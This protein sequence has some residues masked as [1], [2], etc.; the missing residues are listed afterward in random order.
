VSFLPAI[1]VALCLALPTSVH[2]RN[3]DLVP[4]TFVRFPSGAVPDFAHLQSVIFANP[5]ITTSVFE[6]GTY[7]FSQPLL[8]FGRRGFSLCGATGNPAD[9][10]ID[11]TADPAIDI[12]ESQ[13]VT[14]RGLTVTTTASF[15]TA[16]YA[17]SVL[18]PSIE[19]FADDVTVSNC[20]LEGYI[21]AAAAV[22]ARNLTVTGSRITVTQP[23]GAGI[24]WED[25]PGLFVTG[26]RF[27]TAPGI[28]ATVGLFVKG[29]QEAA[30]DGRRA[31][32]I[33]ITNNVVD[34][35]FA[36]GMDLADVVDVRIRRNRVEF[37]SPQFLTVQGGVNV[38]AGRVGIVL[39][40]AAAS[41]L[42]EDFTLLRN[43]VRRAH[44]GIWLFNAGSAQSP[45]TRGR[46][47]GNDLRECAAATADARFGDTG[48][49]VRLNLG[50]GACPLVIDRNDFRD[51]ASPIFEPAVVVFPQGRERN[52]FEGGRARNRLE[53]SRPLHE[54]EP[55]RRASR[56]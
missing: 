41:N 40:R 30:A 14:L 43:V 15:G 34:G 49:A 26:T 36:A 3:D 10:R 31:R 38:L 23:G 18:S 35:D 25:G 21:G 9:V 53:A 24:Q 39:R 56:R 44:Y 1:A 12:L 32:K 2:A 37:P 45:R 52:C 17:A 20:N 8:V 51:L 46:V 7:L 11:S 22:R 4:G 5:E 29:A 33:L 28:S 13:Q 16:V 55:K 54:G 27:A 48:A 47:L 19:N 50:G 6:P 42:T